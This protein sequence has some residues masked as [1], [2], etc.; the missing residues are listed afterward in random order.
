VPLTQIDAAY[1]RVV[2]DACRASS[3]EI[4]GKRDPPVMARVAAIRKFK[5]G[6]APRS[7]RS[8]ANG[9]PRGGSTRWIGA[10]V[11]RELR[12]ERPPVM[13]DRRTWQLHDAVMQV[14]REAGFDSFR[15]ECK[16]GPNGETVIS[17]TLDEKKDADRA[18]PRRRQ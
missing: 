3:A 14:A 9:E 1:I 4:C 6:L 16:V 11:L 13:F 8:H 18:S 2:C 7:R 17:L 15:V 5:R 12:K 10:L